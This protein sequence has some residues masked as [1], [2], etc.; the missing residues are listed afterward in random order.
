MRASLLFPALWLL[1][2]L[3]VP[4]LQAQ[5]RPLGPW[6]LTY[7][8]VDERAD[9]DDWGPVKPAK[10]VLKP[11]PTLVSW[12]I[13]PDSIRLF[14]NCENPLI[15]PAQDHNKQLPIHFTATGATVRLDA[16]HGKLFIM[17]FAST[18]ALSAY[19]GQLLVSKREYKAVPPPLPKMEGLYGGAMP[20]DLRPGEEW[21]RL[22]IRAISSP[23]FSSFMPNDARY[24]VSRFQVSCLRNNALIRPPT[25][26]DGPQAVLG[27]PE[28]FQHCDL[29]QVEVQV[30]QRMNFRG[31][32]ENIRCQER[33]SIPVTPR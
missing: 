4:R 21:R 17:P 25:T 28:D 24:R 31:E 32:V 23:E 33:L 30:V 12:D 16:K 29:I 7:Q 10:K 8:M 11:V 15:T 9:P 3:P 14:L 27:H 13:A 19:R 5:G 26:V 22:F 1:S 18:V 6:R 20:N 2:L